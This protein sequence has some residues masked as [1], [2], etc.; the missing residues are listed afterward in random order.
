MGWFTFP[1]DLNKVRIIIY[2]LPD[3][4][5]LTVPTEQLDS[6]ME[7]GPG[8][9]CDTSEIDGVVHFFPSGHC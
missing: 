6:S 1:F 2:H 9:Y 5:T 4:Q 7:L 8:E 3:G